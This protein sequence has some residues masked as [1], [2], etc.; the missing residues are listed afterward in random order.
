MLASNNENSQYAI[1]AIH[2]HSD[3]KTSAIYTKEA[4]RRAL[5]EHA[6]ASMQNMEW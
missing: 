5:A 3:S 2:G 6:M 4:D 1:M